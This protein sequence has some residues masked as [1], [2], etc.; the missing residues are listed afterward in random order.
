MPG[1]QGVVW[2]CSLFINSQSDNRTAYCFVSTDIQGEL[3]RL[4]RLFL[5]CKHGN[6][7]LRTDVLALVVDTDHKDSKAMG[8]FPLLEK[9]PVR[10]SL[11][12]YLEGEEVPSSWN[13]PWHTSL[14]SGFLSPP[15]WITLRTR[16]H[17]PTERTMVWFP[18]L[19]RLTLKLIWGI[20]AIFTW[21][22]LKVQFSW[23][24]TLL[25]SY[26]LTY[27]RR[28]PRGHF[29]VIQSLRQ[30]TSCTTPGVCQASTK[31]LGFSQE[32]SHL[33]KTQMI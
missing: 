18:I 25:R 13:H 24:L 17:D 23:Q 21:D 1:G 27:F 30:T 2:R 26:L 14:F 19:E 12:S 11:F 15:V 9:V 32:K 16:L 7:E 20:Y 29:S 22:Y 6:W 8:I 10:A 5:F 31:T 3:R 33:S 28:I 4:E